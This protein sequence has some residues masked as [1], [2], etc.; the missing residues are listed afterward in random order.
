MR[1]KSQE[2][3]KRLLEVAAELFA[4]KG[5]NGAGVREICK[6]AKVN[7]S[8]ISY[9]FG[10]KKALY[11]EVFKTYLA[12]A[13]EKIHQAFQKNLQQ[14]PK[15]LKGIV[16]ALAEAVLLT[17]IKEEQRK[18]IFSLL[19]K[20][21]TSE[22]ELSKFVLKEVLN[23]LLTEFSKVVS[24][25]FSSS[26]EVK[27]FVF[28]VVSQ[29]MFFNFFRPWVSDVFGIPNYTPKFK[30]EIVKHIVEFSTC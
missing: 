3:R 5:F 14:K 16:E 23:P 21:L 4:E 28:S 26:K 10:S 11:I 17:P 6:L 22:S 9:H 13:I 30:E 20:E 15:D 19:V 1:Q 12:P 25:F 24:P 27:F 29:I 8:A 7:I 18:N 2:T